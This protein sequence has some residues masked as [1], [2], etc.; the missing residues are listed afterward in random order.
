MCENHLFGQIPKSL[1]ILTSL[2]RVRFNQNNLVGKV[3]EAFGNHPNLTF[4]DLSQN[5]F[6]GEISFNWREIF[7]NYVPSLFP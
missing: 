4:L 3:Y 1:K 7:Q 6:Y 2:K 5:N